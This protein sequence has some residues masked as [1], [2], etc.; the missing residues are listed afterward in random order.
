MRVW[1]LA[2]L[3]VLLGVAAPAAAQ[4]WAAEIVWEDTNLPQQLDCGQEYEAWVTVRNVG[5]STWTALG[6]V[7]LGAVNDSDP[8][9]ANT[10]VYLP[11]NMAVFPNETHTFYFTL[12]GTA[13]PPNP[14]L[15]DWRMVRDA[16]G[17]VWFGEI[18]S[19]WVA[20]SCPL[21]MA[22]VVP[23][24]TDL[25]EELDCGQTYGAQVTM[26]NTGNTTWTAAGGY[27]L[28]DVN[29]PDPFEGPSHVDL[30]PG[31]EVAPGQSHTFT[32]TLTGTPPPPNIKRTDWRMVR[33]GPGG[34]WFG[35]VAGRN[36][37]VYCLTP[38]DNAQV[39]AAQT[40]LPEEIDCG[41]TYQ[42]TVTMMN[43]GTTTWTAGAN[44]RLGAV[45]DS[46]P[47]EGPVRVELPP[48]ASVGPGQSHSFTFTLVGTP[49]PPNFKRTDWRMVRDGA[50]GHWFGQVAWRNVTVYCAPVLDNAEVVAFDLPAG[51]AC[52]QPYPATVTMRNTG[53]TTWTAGEAI[54]LGAAGD[55]DPL[56]G[57]GRVELPPGTSVAPGITH[58]FP[59]ALRA[60][61][62]SGTYLTDWQMV[63][64]GVRW[65]G[66]VASRDVLVSCDDL[67]IPVGHTIPDG[68]TRGVPV[69]VS[70]SMQNRG[71][72]TWSREAG[73]TLRVTGGNFV[74]VGTSYEMPPGVQVPPGEIHRFEFVLVPPFRSFA[75]IELQM[76][77]AGAPFA[78]GVAVDVEIFQGSTCET[79]VSPASGPPGTE[80][81]V[82]PA[83]D[84]V[85]SPASTV[86]FSFGDPQQHGYSRVPVASTVTATQAR[87][88][89]PPGADCGRHYVRVGGGGALPTQPSPF[90]V[91][92]ACNPA[93]RRAFDVVT[94]NAHMLPWP[95]SSHN[96]YRAG[97]IGSH[98]LLQDHDAIVFVEVITVERYQLMEGLR[99]QYPY[100]SGFIP[101]QP[102]GR[103]L[104]GGVFIISKWPIV[105]RNR[106]VFAACNGAVFPPD[107]LAA[108]G[109]NYIG[110]DK[111]GQRFHVLGTHFD[112]NGQDL[113]VLFD[114]LVRSHQMTELRDFTDA[115]QIPASEPVFTAGDFN[116]DR[117]STSDDDVEEYQRLL[118]RL[119]ATDPPS[120]PGET[121]HENG[122]WIDYV[123]NPSDHVAPVESFNYVLR[124]TQPTGGNLSDHFAVWGRFRYDFSAAAAGAPSVLAAP[125][126][127]PVAHSPSGA[128]ASPY[129]R[130]SWSPVDGATSY[131]FTV[132]RAGDTAALAHHSTIGGVLFSPSLPL[133]AGVDLEWTVRGENEAGP[134]PESDPVPF[135][136]VDPAAGPSITIADASVAEGAGTATLTLSLSAPAST[137]VT[138]GFR[139]LAGTAR[140]GA[141]FTEV[142][143]TVS[144][145]QNVTSQTV[146]VPIAAD[147]L[148]EANEI[149]FVALTNAVGAT[150]GD[151]VA[152]VTILDD[153]PPPTVSIGDITLMEGNSGTREAV[154]QVSLSVPSGLPVTVPYATRNGSATTPEDYLAA[155]GV[156]AFAEGETTKTVPVAVVGD[157]VWE[158]AETVFVDL[159]GPTNA[160][161]A[162]GEGR[163]S[164][165][166]DDL[167]TVSIGDVSFAEGLTGSALVP[168]LTVSLNA[169]SIVDVTVQ[170]TT[171]DCTA[172]SGQDYPAR[173]GSVTFRPGETVKS[174]EV[175]WFDDVGFEASETYLVQLHSPTQATIADGRG[176][177]TLVNDD[178][179]PDPPLG[180]P[181][182]DFNGDGKTD[183]IWRHGTAGQLSAWLMDGINLVHGTVFDTLGDLGWK[184]VG[185]ADFDGDARP[186]LL[187]HH[188]GSGQ[189]AVWF[190]NGLVRT[191][192]V[193]LDGM[194]DTAWKVAGTGDFDK[195]RRPDILWRNEGSG[196]LSAWLMDGTAVADAVKLNPDR[197][198]DLDWRIKGTGD[199][200]HDGQTD[201]LWQHQQ[202]HE[203]VA[204]LMAGVNQVGGGF[205]TPRSVGDPAWKVAAAGDFNGDEQTD[206]LWRHQASGELV[207]WM[208]NGTGLTCGVFMNPDRLGDFAWEVV[209]PR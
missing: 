122:G 21:D 185:T 172:V 186:D 28:G 209:G 92:G 164:I 136:V 63:R 81:T 41:Q 20:V 196:E 182:A 119:R 44:Y 183:L 116:I 142:S 156:L 180:L 5:V 126:A 33:E 19:S 125:K 9:T 80:V 8:F 57:P 89:V 45:D 13:P 87:F 16:P 99:E 72:S 2:T 169:P 140:A 147:A 151:W 54:R 6:E 163:I 188:Q 82:T 79:S 67:A 208:M 104:N 155:S 46:D 154:L 37:N 7:K 47:L 52:G 93:R 168:R 39:V 69:A 114:R 103:L 107:C 177:V 32:F 173:S 200:N 207:T 178:P 40:D 190:M 123:F 144:F 165:V 199:F 102:P 76:A 24:E 1:W 51:L 60:P 11:P 117:Q 139:A 50:G 22:L 88:T 167:P 59:L 68:M 71:V 206:I 38:E 128:L 3:M 48:G 201:I 193:V 194:S 130:F 124:P 25:P 26:R 10:R 131:A 205:L 162:D 74:A 202:S 43:T 105:A 175:G 134:G 85:F 42:A 64:E 96:E 62:A 56:G 35:A 109:V 179:N 73:Y 145:P 120:L 97:F 143:G 137:D 176:Q 53:T 153:D 191:G 75:R 150:I 90:E 112:A 166:N 27:R 31:V 106:M 115:L 187:W 161:I 17:G 138:V 159:G 14:K 174:I 36:V 34:A 78:D 170:Y 198:E 15:T 100:F 146:S 135:R 86:T 91:V 157:T 197:V 77:R 133:P 171:A 203:L 23:D 49:P 18:A 118:T 192:G 101:A 94:Y 111:G 84:C 108:K 204:W 58:A 152:E 83:P 129:Q 95:G 98:P 55:S 12:T 4:Q 29:T 70:V 65:F 132:R 30:P 61:L 189:L 149:L 110:V 184:V 141:D 66:G 121:T 181:P 148:D 195:D 113:P 158:Q 160:V 127:A